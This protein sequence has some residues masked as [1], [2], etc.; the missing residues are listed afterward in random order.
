MGSSGRPF[1]AVQVSGTG[2]ALAGAP[3]TRFSVSAGGLPRLPTSLNGPRLAAPR[4]PRHPAGIS[5]QA[6]G[7][8]ISTCC[9]SPTPCGLGLGPTHPL[10]IDRAAETLDIR[11]WGFSPHESLLI[12]TF[13]LAFAP[14][15]LALML[16]RAATLPYHSQMHSI[17]ESCASAVRLAPVH[18]RRGIPR[19]V[20]CYALFQGWLLLSQ[21]PGCLRAATSLPTQP[22]LGDLSRRSRLFP[23][24]RRIFAP[25]ASLPRSGSLGIRRLIRVGRRQAPSPIQCSTPQ[26]PPRGCT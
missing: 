6:N 5:T 22:V 1:V 20:S 2:H 17:Q 9:P 16:Q 25:A 7:A 23:S 10:R 12:P 13:A 15:G 24:R 19:P 3:R 21:P 11:R 8:G 18:C 14:H 4:P 26:R